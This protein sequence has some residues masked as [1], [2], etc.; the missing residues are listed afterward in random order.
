MIV[1]DGV[2]E[3]GI[4]QGIHIKVQLSDVWRSLPRLVTEVD[5]EITIC[6]LNHGYKPQNGKSSDKAQA[7]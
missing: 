1:L 5:Y 6:S 3:Y 2:C 4:Y 7:V